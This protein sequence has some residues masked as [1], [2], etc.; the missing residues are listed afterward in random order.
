MEE[1]RIPT[2]EGCEHCL[3]LEEGDFFCDELDELCIEDWLSVLFPT[4][5]YEQEEKEMENIQIEENELDQEELLKRPLIASIDF[6]LSEDGFIAASAGTTEFAR[7]Y[8]ILGD[9][10]GKIKEII[11]KYFRK[12]MEEAGIE[13][14]KINNSAVKNS[15]QVLLQKLVRMNKMEF[16]LDVFGLNLAEATKYIRINKAI[17]Q[18]RRYRME[19]NK[20]SESVKVYTIRNG[21]IIVI[22]SFKNG[23]LVSERKIEG[24]QKN[25]QQS[26]N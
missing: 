26:K 18:K 6:R 19:T 4:G 17:D 25:G 1:N 16:N 3:Y 12:P 5:C 9:K 21:K 13:I 20:N 8:E 2:C 10:E 24:D 11:L 22:T 14:D 23:K 7:I 15:W